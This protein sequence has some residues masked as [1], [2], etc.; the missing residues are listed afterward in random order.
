MNKQNAIKINYRRGSASASSSHLSPGNTWDKPLPSVIISH[1]PAPLQP[2][3]AA[4]R[5]QGGYMLPSDCRFRA[6]AT[7]SCSW[8]HE[9]QRLKTAA[10]HSLTSSLALSKIFTFPT[11]WYVSFRRSLLDLRS[12]SGLWLTART[13]R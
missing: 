13:P 6:L 8:V 2:N 10:R 1:R 7:C 5:P 3:H 4:S 12:V 11:P 9:S